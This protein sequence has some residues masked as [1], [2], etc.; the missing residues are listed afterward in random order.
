MNRIQRRLKDERAARMRRDA[1]HI[2]T[3]GTGLVVLMV[4]AIVSNALRFRAGLAVPIG[5]LGAA[6]GLAALYSDR[7][8]LWWAVGALW[9]IRNLERSNQRLDELNIKLDELNQR[10]ETLRRLSRAQRRLVER[11]MKFGS[12]V[13][14]AV[15]TLVIDGRLEQARGI[16]DRLEPHLPLLTEAATFGVLEQV[17]AALGIDQVEH[18]RAVVEKARG[19]NK[20]IAEAGPLGIADE[21]R[22]YVRAGNFDSARAAIALRREIDEQRAYLERLTRR[23][24]QADHRHRPALTPLLTAASTALNQGSR[25][26]RQAVHELE[27][28]IERVGA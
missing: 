1:R 26:F 17:V 11:S 19:Q 10:R 9:A 24:A 18:A 7:K 14:A 3:R 20:L 2:L 6:F 8:Q 12:S 15:R 5:F 22:D 16:L 25:E 21:V 13:Q 23:V 28:A 27:R 4:L